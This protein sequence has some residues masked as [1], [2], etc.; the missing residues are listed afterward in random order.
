MINENIWIGV[1]PYNLTMCYVEGWGWHALKLEHTFE[2]EGK[3]LKSANIFT[4]MRK[5]ITLRKS[6]K[7]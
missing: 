6:N 7:L 2:A 5:L 1:S 4:D 3:R